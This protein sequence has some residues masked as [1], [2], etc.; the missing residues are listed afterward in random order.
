[1]IY[2]A[3][4]QALFEERSA[5]APSIQSNIVKLVQAG[6][7]EFDTS[8]YYAGGLGTG[9]QS[10]IVIDS[11]DAMKLFNTNFNRF[12]GQ[13]TDQDWLEYLERTDGVPYEYYSLSK[14]F[15]MTVAPR[16]QITFR[17]W[18]PI[19]VGV[20]YNAEMGKAAFAANS[21]YDPDLQWDENSFVLVSEGIGFD[22]RENTSQDADKY[23]GE[24]GDLR[25]SPIHWQ[26]YKAGGNLKGSYGDQGYER[27]LG[28]EWT[29]D[30][31]DYIE[32]IHEEKRFIV[33]ASGEVV[34]DNIAPNAGTFPI[35][36]GTISAANYQKT[37]EQEDIQGLLDDPITEDIDETK[38]ATSDTAFSDRVAEVKRLLEEERNGRYRNGSQT[39]GS[40]FLA[41][42]AYMALTFIRR[43]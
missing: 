39:I 27:T 32:Y 37:E 13:Y 17:I 18:Q 9:G 23:A 11:A 14:S 36:I 7:I 2:T 20:N 15:K 19:P 28:A 40:A 29:L 1:L 8:N 22:G 43:G 16:F 24:F 35:Q 38:D 31:G 21:N 5:K 6:V 42:L 3:E 12:I 41:G 10:N 34:T 26:Q 30:E 25:T 4:E 33:V